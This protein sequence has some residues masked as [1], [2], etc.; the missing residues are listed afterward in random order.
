MRCAQFGARFEAGLQQM[1]DGLLEL[2]REKRHD[3]F[4]EHLGR[5]KQRTL[6]PASTIGSRWSPRK[7]ARRWQRSLCRR[8]RSPDESREPRRLLRACLHTN[9]FS[10]GEVKLWRT[11]SMLTDLE[12]VCRSLKGKLGMRPIYHKRDARSDGHLIITVLA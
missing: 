9:E 1:S 3:R 2:R 10:S 6:A 11:Y 8:C 5:L 12:S 4:L 7:P